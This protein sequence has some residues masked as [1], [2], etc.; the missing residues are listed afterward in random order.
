M[1]CIDFKISPTESI[2]VLNNYLGKDVTINTI[3]IGGC[4]QTFDQPFD[5]GEQA[6][7]TLTGCDNGLLDE[8]FR[9]DLV[10]VYTTESFGLTKTIDGTVSTKIQ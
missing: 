5:N 9:E 2:V 3:S 7:F 10:I 4:N 8:S 6:I 1:A